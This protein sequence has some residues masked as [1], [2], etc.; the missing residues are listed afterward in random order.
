MSE[1]LNLKE[2]YERYRD[3]GLVLIGV[4][5]EIGGENMPDLVYSLDLP[6]P[7]AVDTRGHTEE[8]YN[9]DSHPDFYLIDRQGRVRIAD[10]MD[11][12]LERAIELVLREQPA[13]GGGD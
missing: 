10:L 8:A 12:E 13:E 6:Y 2:L 9:V 7:V 3:Q 11:F 4:H 1:L 5:T